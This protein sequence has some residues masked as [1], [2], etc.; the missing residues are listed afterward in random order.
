[1]EPTTTVLPKTKTT[2]A[3]VQQ[4]VAAPMDISGDAG[5]DAFSKALFNVQDIDA[6]DKE[7]PQLVSEYVN[8]IYEYMRVLEAS[9]NRFNVRVSLIVR[10][11]LKLCMHLDAQKQFSSSP[12]LVIADGHPPFEAVM[13][14][15]LCW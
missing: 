3:Q 4:N 5:P 10:D 1:M 2:A 15:L 12:G 11:S 14:L 6:S 8:D 7:N 9:T 13:L